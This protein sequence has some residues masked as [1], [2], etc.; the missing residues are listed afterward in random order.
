MIETTISSSINV[1][2]F[3][4]SLPVLPISILRSIER[5]ILALS[6][7]VINIFATPTRGIGCILVT[8]KKPIRFPR[9]GI[10]RESPEIAPDCRAPDRRFLTRHLN[11]Q[12]HIQ[13]F[14]IPINAGDILTRQ[15]VLQTQRADERVSIA[16]PLQFDRVD[17]RAHHPQLLTQ[18]NL[19]RTLP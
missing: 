1:K 15:L 12:Q 3:G 17:C 6:Q 18:F 10:E 13:R 5:N 14:W 9:H 2:P 16:V 7:Y 4:V 8:T 11:A 19:V